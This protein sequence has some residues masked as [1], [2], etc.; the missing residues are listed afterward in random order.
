MVI[1]VARTWGDE[2]AL[3]IQRMDSAQAALAGLRGD[4]AKTDELV[5]ALGDGSTWDEPFEA[6]RDL[7]ENGNRGLWEAW[8]STLAVPAILGRAADLHPGGAGA[9]SLRHARAG[10]AVVAETL[11]SWIAAG[12]RPESVEELTTTV[13]AGLAEAAAAARA[14]Q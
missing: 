9:E 8:F 14:V 3:G 12:G 2:V 13:G 11:D 1:G 5:R 7:A 4:A 10:A 6:L